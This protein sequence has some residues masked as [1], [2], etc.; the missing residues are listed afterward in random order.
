MFQIKE[1]QVNGDHVEDES[2]EKPKVDGEDQK[3][4]DKHGN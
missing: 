2:E 4:E 1:E 3:D